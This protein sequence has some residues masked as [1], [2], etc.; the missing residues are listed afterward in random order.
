MS[1]KKLSHH[2]KDDFVYHCTQVWS[3]DVKQASGY[4]QPLLAS[5]EPAVVLEAASGI[6]A[7]ASACGGELAAAPDL[8]FGALLDLWDAEPTGA[9]RAQLLDVL[10]ANLGALHVRVGAPPPDR[11]LRPTF[12]L[13]PSRAHT[14]DVPSEGFSSS[15]WQIPHAEVGGSPAFLAC[16]R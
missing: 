2:H 8:A 13:L 6:L 1:G 10:S 4:L 16:R 5:V 9:A 3:C 7:L 15:L 11:A 12:V 14:I